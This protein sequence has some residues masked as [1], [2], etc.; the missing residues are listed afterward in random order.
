MMDTLLL[1]LNQELIRN[2]QLLRYIRSRVK[3]IDDVADI[4]QECILRVIER[5]QTQQIDNLLA[6]AIRVVCNLI[7]NQP[8]G[9]IEEFDELHCELNNPE[10]L[11]ENQ[12]HLKL[13]Y[14]ALQKM[15]PQRRRVFEMR[16]LQGETR[17]Q[18]ALKLG[19]N[20]DTVSRHL[21]RAMADLHRAPG[22]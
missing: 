12:Q 2:N 9:L 22:A 14:Q 15:P 10:T 17:Q 18:V 20:D 13:I 8:G 21:N 1:Q 5:T 3:S 7:K 16:R 19:L 6:Y 11:A 4:Y